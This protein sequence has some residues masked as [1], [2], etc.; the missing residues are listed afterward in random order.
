MFCLVLQYGC[1]KVEK[2]ICANIIGNRW[3][4]LLLTKPSDLHVVKT[5]VHVNRQI[6]KL[7]SLN[8]VKKK[9]ANV[10]IVRQMKEKTS[11]CVDN[12]LLPDSN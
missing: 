8:D 2:T 3:T 1:L 4:F 7:Y 11:T 6:N 10:F 12:A 5:M 9:N